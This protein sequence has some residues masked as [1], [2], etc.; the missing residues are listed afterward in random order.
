MKEE[1][2]DLSYWKENAKGAYMTTPLCVLRYIFELEKAVKNNALLPHVI[3]KICNC[4]P[5]AAIV[6]D[7]GNCKNCG[8]LLLKP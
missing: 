1:D 5:T 3:D 6:D 8:N 7:K 2:K 4:S